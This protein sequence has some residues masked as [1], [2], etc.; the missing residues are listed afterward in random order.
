LCKELMHGK[1]AWRDAWKRRMA[2]VYGMEEAHGRGV[3][4]S[5]C[6]AEC[7]HGRVYAWQRRMAEV[8]GRVYARQWCIHCTVDNH[9][10]Q[11]A[12]SKQPSFVNQRHVA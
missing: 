11:R 3:W 9:V 10:I 6:T 5:V 2:E 7:M 8:Y 12:S 1:G 4:Q